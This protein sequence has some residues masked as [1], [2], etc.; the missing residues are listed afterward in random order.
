MLA[1]LP[2]PP[3]VVHAAAPAAPGTPP[4]AAALRTYGPG[5]PQRAEVEDFIRRV[6]RSRYGADVTT[7]AP[8]LVG[9]HDTDGTLLAAAG[10]RSAAA[11]ALFLE[12]YLDA[13]IERCLAPDGAATP[14]RERIVEVGHLAGDRAG[15]GRRLVLLLAPHLAAAGHQWVVSTLTQ[16]LRHLFVRLGIAPLALGVADPAL[17]GDD[18]ARWGTYYDHRPVVL[19]GQLEP[20]LQALARR[21]RLEPAA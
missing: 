14:A 15:A 10:Y 11:G 18:A 7:F 6:Y 1:C 8:V 20:A 4:A 16:E 17:L 2:A 19:A 3:D 21:H 9:L 13:P 12:R 5:A